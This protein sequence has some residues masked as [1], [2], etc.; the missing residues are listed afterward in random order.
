VPVEG[1]EFDLLADALIPAIGQKA[2]LGFISP[3]DGIEITRWETIKT[4]PYTMMTTRPGVFAAGDA[5]SGPLTVVHGIAGGKQAARMMHQYITTGKC[6]PSEGQWIQNLITK[7]EQD[8]G[9]LVT[10]RTPS[11]SGGKRPQ[12]KLDVRQRITNFREVDSGF[13]QRSSFIEA[14]RCLRC[15]HL[16]LAAVKETEVES[17][18]M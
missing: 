5:V 17:A 2:D 15:F 1:S 9:V 11:R 6:L 14:S 4:D 16:V 18:A 12:R 10:A 8:H 7:I 3:R 13:T